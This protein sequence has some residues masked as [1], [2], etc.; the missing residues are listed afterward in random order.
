MENRNRELPACFS[1]RKPKKALPQCYAKQRLQKKTRNTDERN[2]KANAQK[3]FRRLLPHEAIP[4]DIKNTR[5]QSENQLAEHHIR[6]SEKAE[7]ISAETEEW[8]Q[9]RER[10]RESKEAGKPRWREREGERG[11]GVF[12]ILWE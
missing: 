12:S 3:K 10:E 5:I 1:P 6:V 11:K 9:L 4:R 8:T 7:R 2:K